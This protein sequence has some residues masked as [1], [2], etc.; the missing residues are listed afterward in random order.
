MSA[1]PGLIDWCCRPGNGGL[2][3]RRRELWEAIAGAGV[4][5]VVVA[6]RP[7]SE[8]EGPGGADAADVPEVVTAA[9]LGPGVAGELDERDRQ[10]ARERLEADLRAFDRGAVGWIGLDFS[11]DP[12]VEVR[13]RQRQLFADQLEVARRFELPVLVRAVEAY[14]SLLGLLRKH[15]RLEAGGVLDGFEGS[16]RQIGPL[17]MVGLDLSVGPALLGAAADQLEAAVCEVPADRLH[18]ATGVAGGQ[19]GEEPV[20]PDI[21]AIL[22]R[23]GRLRGCSSRQIGRQMA[24]SSR[25]LLGEESAVG[26]R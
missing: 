14:N 12:A 21:D 18:L 16:T 8:F 20:Y 2:D 24:T 6:V 11:G 15:G 4:S 19:T 7:G 5:T 9:G 17:L 3:R 13:R 23:I 1:G 26:G 10:Q 22:E 25:R